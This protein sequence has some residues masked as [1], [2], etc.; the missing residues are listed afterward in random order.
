MNNVHVAKRVS[1]TV[2]IGRKPKKYYVRKYHKRQYSLQLSKDMPTQT[3]D[4][5]PPRIRIKIIKTK[6]TR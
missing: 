1:K 4:I 3:E 5:K 6:R 2:K